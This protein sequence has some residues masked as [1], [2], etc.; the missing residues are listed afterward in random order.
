[1]AM[2]ERFVTLACALGA[3]LLFVTI[4]MRSEGG[5]DSRHDVPRPTTEDRRGNGYRAAM[6]W[7][8]EEHVR[9]ISLRQRFD[10]LAER[11]ALPPSGNVLIVTLPATT[12]FKTEEFRPL[13]RWVRAGNTLVVLAALSDNPDWAF[14]LGGLASGD[15]NLLTGLEFETVKS[16]EHRLL[17]PGRPAKRRP[18]LPSA[19]DGENG[20]G[21]NLGERIAAAARAFAEPQRA[22]LVPNRPHAYFSGVREAVALSDYPRQAWTVKVPYEGFVLSLAHERDTGEGVLWTRPLGDGR[23]IVSGFGSLFTN[24]V[25]GLADNGRLL[26]NIVGANLGPD[27]AVV[28]DDVHQGLGGTYDPEKFYKDPRLYYTVG[29]LALL[30]LSWVLGSTRLRMPLTRDAIPREAELVRAT[31]GFLA[32]VLRPDAGARRLFEHFFRRVS[33]RAAFGRDSGGPP[34]E[35]LERQPRVSPADVKQ[36]RDWYAAASA[37][38]RVPLARLHNLIVRIDRQLA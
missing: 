16:R 9:T 36:L 25:V 21:S 11:P 5:L 30:W 8:D 38:R 19:A 35:F 7:L 29:I 33:E 23:I 15:L 37:S 34:W 27:G 12:G 22:A 26:A 6:T 13:D 10:K 4:F 32:R 20:G 18:A 28:F 24:R 3:L 31:G 17:D 1:M 2:R 14:A